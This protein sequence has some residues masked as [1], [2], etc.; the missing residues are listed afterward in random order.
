M[1]R[2]GVSVLPAIRSLLFMRGMDAGVRVNVSNAASLPPWVGVSH[3]V[4]ECA[5][6]RA[7]S[8]SAHKPEMHKPLF[9]V[10]RKDTGGERQMRNPLENRPDSHKPGGFIH[11][12]LLPFHPADINIPD[13]QCAQPWAL[14]RGNSTFL[15][16][17]IKPV[18][19]VLFPFSECYPGVCR[20]YGDYLG[21]GQE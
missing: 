20:T 3:I 6:L 17:L 8:N 19:A 1:L 15:P 16:F 11:H 12:F 2:R 21:F 10:P 14:S 5:P 4:E 18:L 7:D 13:Q 9:L